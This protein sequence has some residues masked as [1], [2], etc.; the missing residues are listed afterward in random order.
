LEIV[1]RVGLA[2]PFIYD[3]LGR[4]IQKKDLVDPNN[5]RLYYHNHN[6]QVLCGYDNS[7]NVKSFFIYGNYI[8]EVV[9]MFDFTTLFYGYFVHDHLYSPA[10]LTDSS[11]TVLERY[12]YD[13]YGNCS[14]LEP[15]FAP[16]PDGKSDYGNPYLFTGRRLD[17]LD[18]SSLKIQ[19]NRNR[20]YDYYTGRWL[21]QDPL[22]I[23]PNPQKPNE[24]GITNQYRDGINLYEY[25]MSRATSGLDPKG[26]KWC[27]LW[28]FC[29]G[30]GCCGVCGHKLS[31]SVFKEM[32]EDLKEDFERELEK[33][34]DAKDK[35]CGFL[36]GFYTP[37]G[38]EIVELHE[39]ENWM[40]SGCGTKGCFDTVEINGKCYI[41]HEV[42]Y[43]L[44]GLANRLCGV[45]K[46]K[47]MIWAF[48]WSI[49]KPDRPHCKVIWTEAG[50][51]GRVSVVGC[52]LDNCETSC[53]RRLRTLTPYLRGLHESIR[54][55][56]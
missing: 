50:Y 6:W 7:N 45:P 51:A 36:S 2:P 20:Y 28:P 40:T 29:R 41:T 56:K 3:A 49:D 11:G 53:D 34:P 44:W 8:D 24:F 48:A 14:I 25:V 26:L 43:Y 5:T 37:W 13:A 17:I 1:G 10:A 22:G 52:T 46:I 16:D 23:T 39:P 18:N 38:W 21:T 47:A 30:R 12:E 19:Y 27:P 54:W 31:K 33:D 35:I 32:E 15:N 4:R 55:G 9:Y 42:N